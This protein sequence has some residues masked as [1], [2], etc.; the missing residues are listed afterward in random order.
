MAELIP[1]ICKRNESDAPPYLTPHCVHVYRRIMVFSIFFYVHMYI[2]IFTTF[3]F[4]EWNYFSLTLKVEA[5]GVVAWISLHGCGDIAKMRIYYM[6]AGKSKN[7]TDK[8]L[9]DTF[10]Y[11]TSTIYNSC[12]EDVDTN[13]SFTLKLWLLYHMYIW[14]CVLITPSYISIPAPYRHVTTSE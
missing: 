4:I 14:V 6:F 13:G 8:T 3:T 7:V 10:P 1:E 5:Y 12:D 2:R 11:V 9:K